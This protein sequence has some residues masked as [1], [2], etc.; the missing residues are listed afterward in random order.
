MKKE[1]FELPKDKKDLLKLLNS[2]KQL[3]DQNILEG[4]YKIF[5]EVSKHGDTAVK[6]ITE[7]FDKVKIPNTKLD[8]DYINN[9]VEN[10][11]PSLSEMIKKAITNIKEVNQLL[12]PTSWKKEVRVGTVVG[13]KV[14]P[15]DSVG[16]WV[17]ARKGPLIS[18]ALMLVVAAK[19]AGV[20][21]IVV[22]MPPIENGLGDPGTVAAAKIAGAD[23]FII[24]NGVSVIAGFSKGTDSIPEVDGI[25]GPGPSGVAASMNV[26]NSYGKKTIV[27]IGPTESAIIADE[28]A[29]P[30][31][32]AYDLI[33]EAE[34]G[35][36]SAAILAT[37][38]DKL[39]KKV[40]EYLF[41]I[42][43]KT[44]GKR[45]ENLLKVFG[46]DGMGVIV[47]AETI[48][49][50]CEF[51]N[52]F[53]PEHLMINCQS[54][55]QALILEKI[56]NAGEILLGEHTPFS[57]ANYGIGITAV[58]PTNGFAKAYSGITSRDMV[59]YSTIGS[60]NKQAL[61]EIL[62][63]IKEFGQYETLPYHIK[64]AEMRFED[65]R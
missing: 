53:A 34:H 11:S 54:N 58:L 59:K 44:E 46:S 5:Q 20:K 3:F 65:G 13:E 56:S 1:I 29:D 37:T 23:E 52:D 39:A 26:A 7:E 19:V 10:L 21:K 57:S 63:I 28:E 41:N 6:M 62:P 49:I 64:V 24:G 14:T 40:N 16:L 15:L 36:D 50:L 45:K 55:D 51:I 22:G 9:C 30:K 33:N 4:I 25:F 35:P 61:K 38:S 48:D 47:V 27:G 12:V 31:A 18:T 42:I 32:V 43:D 17:P 8:D 2:H 60:L